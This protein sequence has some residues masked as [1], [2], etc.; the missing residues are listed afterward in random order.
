[1]VSPSRPPATFAALLRRHRIGAGLTQE[2]LAE[3]AHLSVRGLS[4]LERRVNRTPRPLTVS[5]LADALGLTADA[6]MVL[7]AAARGLHV[8]AVLPPTATD[9]ATPFVGRAAEIAAVES[10]LAGPGLGPPLLLFAGEPGIGK[11][12]LLHLAAERGGDAGYTVLRGGCRR[13]S[14]QDPYAPLVEALACYIDRHAP[15]RLRGALQGCDGLVR[16][17]PE[18]RPFVGPL[19][20]D[21]LP[22][23]Q[24]RRLLFGAVARFLHNLAGP[25][26]ALLVVDDLHWA[27]GDALDLLDA[28]ARAASDIPLRI[29][30]AYRDTDVDPH[31]PL[32]AYLADFAH[33]ALA[34]HIALGALAPPEAAALLGDDQHSDTGER[35]HVLQWSGGIPFFLVS[36]AQALQ[37]RQPHGGAIAQG[38][39]TPDTDIPWDLAQG[40]RQRGAALPLKARDLLTAVAIGGRMVPQSVLIEVMQDEPDI[41]LSG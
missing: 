11:S 27:G 32:S 10:H 14:G 25:A 5:L 4:D 33:Q 35:H 21:D 8:P 13:G 28:L 9:G 24:Q 37:A 7:E 22:P 39:T 30:G 41:V 34:R 38:G 6:R 31:A 17:L 29:V 23:A 36:Y 16:L 40:I 15:A 18:V 19:P 2:A 3:R 12:R 1:M 20:R 26:G